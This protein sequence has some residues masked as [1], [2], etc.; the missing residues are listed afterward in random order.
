VK[1]ENPKFTTPILGSKSICC[2]K[3]PTM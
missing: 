3:L 2:T 1:L